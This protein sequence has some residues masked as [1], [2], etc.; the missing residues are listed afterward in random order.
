M[1][2]PKSKY[3]QIILLSELG[4]DLIEESKFREAISK[5][6]LAL[7]LVPNPK[8]D[9]EASTWLY[10]AIGDALLYDKQYDQAIIYFNRAIMCPNG[11]SNPYIYFKLGATYSE[12]ELI[13]QAQEN[14]LK[15][16]MLDGI[17]IFQDHDKEF[18]NLIK[19]LI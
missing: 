15:A 9:F 17:E 8:E 10:V 1:E 13:P 16:Y 3:D 14:F 19:H 2:I 6:E 7:R 18:F 5:Y 12:K 11:I 4:D